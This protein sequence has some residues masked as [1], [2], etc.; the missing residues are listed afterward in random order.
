[1][2]GVSGRCAQYTPAYVELAYTLYRLFGWGMRQVSG[3][4]A[5]YWAS[6]HLELP[7]PSFGHLCDLFAALNVSVTRRCD[8]LAERLKD[9]ESVSLIVDSTGLRFSHA[10]EWYEVKYGTSPD[11]TPWRKLHI[12]MNLDWDIHAT[13]V[14]DTTVGD[15]PAMDDLLA[16]TADV[17][18]E[19]VLADG[20]YYDTLRNETLLKNG[21]FPVIP[22]PANAVV[23][24][25][26][27]HDQLVD[28]I[29]RKGTIYAFH[30]KYGYG[31][32][33]RV[34]AQFSRIKRCIGNTLLTRKIESQENEGVVVANIIN[35]WN[36]L[37]MCVSVKNA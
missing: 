31:L 12:S 7:V 23:G 13:K 18:V 30:K 15:S 17:K 1:V 5:D 16:K 37:G 21:T 9:G 28:Y 8:R 10:R 32:R 2:E 4:L 22:P 26:G 6:Q 24:K 35:F 33:S 36:S 11:R 27:L 29:E 20:A 25:G 3:Y 34:E 19:K 14:T